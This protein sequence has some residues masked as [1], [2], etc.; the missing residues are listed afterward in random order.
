MVT[1]DGVDPCLVKGNKFI[2]HLGVYVGVGGKLSWEII[3]FVTVFFN[4]STFVM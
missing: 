4:N 2:V 1:A 3:T